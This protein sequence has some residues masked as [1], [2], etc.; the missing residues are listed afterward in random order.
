MSDYHSYF[1]HSVSCGASYTLV[2]DDNGYVWAFGWNSDGQLGVGDRAE[3]QVPTRIDTLPEIQMIATGNYQSLFLDVNGQVWGCGKNDRNQ[4]G[5]GAQ[6]PNI[7]VPEPINIPAAIKQIAIGDNQSF[8]VDVER[9]VWCMRSKKITP[10]DAEFHLEVNILEGLPQI[11]FITAKD[12]NLYLLDINGEVW[13]CGN[14]SFSQLGVATAAFS[15]K[16]AKIQDLSNIRFIAT[17]GINAVFL[18]QQF[19]VYGVGC[20]TNGQLGRGSNVLQPTKFLDQKLNIQL[21]SCEVK[22]TIL[23]DNKGKAW[24]T[25]PKGHR[26]VYLKFAKVP[27]IVY[28]NSGPTHSVFLDEYGGLWTNYLQPIPKSTDKNLRLTKVDG[29]PIVRTT[30]QGTI[31]VKSARKK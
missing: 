22:K 18:D 10:G 12:G 11:E 13:S 1:P 24:C 28:I 21:V 6:R 27:R 26:K 5:L 19:C 9:Q 3:R 20:S 30:F 15:E 2:I 14:N 4:L 23:L 7:L 29:A 17:G 16:P 8:F 31:H 25:A